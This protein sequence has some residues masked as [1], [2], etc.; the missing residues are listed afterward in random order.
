MELRA[1][2]M[3]MMTMIVT[4][5]EGTVTRHRE[6]GDLTQFTMLWEI[7]KVAATVRTVIQIVLQDIAL[8]GVFNHKIYFK[9]NF[10][11]ISLFLCIICQSMYSQKDKK[12]YIKDCKC[13]LCI[14]E[15]VFVIV[16]VSVYLISMY[17]M[18]MPEL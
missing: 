7:T 2:M 1:M 17:M 8:L 6:K 14:F 12:N 4:V 15:Y 9:S 13:V 18:V 10:M 16:F 3:R 11:Q 5:V